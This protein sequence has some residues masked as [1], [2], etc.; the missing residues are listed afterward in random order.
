M[1]EEP[2]TSDVSGTISIGTYEEIK[3]WCT[4]LGCTEVELAEAIA[5]AGYSSE[6]VRVLLD[7]QS[8]KRICRQLRS[9]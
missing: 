5:T 9:C 4:K 6:S 8:L 2:P 7:S 1:Q 3:A